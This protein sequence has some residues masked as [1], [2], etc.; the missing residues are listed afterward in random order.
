M[1][2]RQHHAPYRHWDITDVLPDR[3]NLDL[4][5]A[6]VPARTWPGWV[7]YSSLWETGKRTCRDQ[8]DMPA[9]VVAALQYLQSLEFTRRLRQL[10]GI[11][12]LIPA[13]FCHGGG[14][15]VT[16]QGGRLDPHID[17]AV[18]PD[19]PY[20]ERRLSLILFCN[21]HTSGAL[22]LWTDDARRVVVEYFPVAN[23][24]VLFENS[25]VSFH[26]VSRHTGAADRVTLAVYYCA[27]IRPGVSRKRALWAPMRDEQ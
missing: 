13:P 4:L 23:R 3:F 16:E 1:D 22:Q 11:D 20:L 9:A 27:P 21:T 19:A 6:S 8:A 25:D 18:H 5:T 14:L 12:G 17:F 24:A 26:S 7:T 2:V 15:H 10:S